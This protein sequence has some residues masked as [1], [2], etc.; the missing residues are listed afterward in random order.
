MIFKSL[1][2]GIFFAFLTLFNYNEGFSQ[3][4]KFGDISVSEFKKT[5][6]DAIILFKYRETKLIFKNMSGWTLQTKVHERIKIN[7][8]KGMDYATKKIKLYNEYHNNDE[9]F[10][11]KAAT[12]N[13][14]NEAIT[15]TKFL[16]KSIYK[17][18]L[19]DR[20]SRLT[21]TMPD[22]KENAIIE[23]E[24]TINS[25]YIFYI[26]DIV[27]QEDIPIK[28]FKA[29]VNIPGD[30]LKFIYRYLNKIDANITNKRG[31]YIENKNV[32]KFKNE[33]FTRNIELYRPKIVF[34]VYA[35]NFPNE[36]YKLYSKTWTDVAKRLN[37][38]ENFGMQLKKSKY[39]K[40]ELP[41]ILSNATSKKDS[42]L[43][44]FNFVK[45]RVKWNGI[46]FIFSKKGVKTA[47]NEKTGNVAEINFILVSMLRKVGFKA[48]PLILNTR[49]RYKALFPTILKVNYVICYVDLGNKDVLL[50]ASDK[51][52]YYNV[53]PYKTLNGVGRVIKKDNTSF[54]VDL[55][56]KTF[57]VT[58]RNISLKINSTG[59]VTGKLRSIF[60]GEKAIINRDRL[61]DLDPVA[62]ELELKNKF[63][64]AHINKVKFN[65]KDQL[66]KPF[67]VSLDFIL[68][69]NFKTDDRIEIPVM[70]LFKQNENII[71]DSK[72]KFPIEFGYPY[73]ESTIQSINLP[74]GYKV[75]KLPENEL[76]KSEDAKM[77]FSF[78]FKQS[79]GMLYIKKVLVLI[80][81]EIL[82]KDYL[83]FK[84]VLSK[85]I[86]IE[87]KSI[88]LVPDK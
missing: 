33:N 15:K 43:A 78:S 49:E 83:E 71:K 6:D 53:L 81:T 58:K 48:D 46:H 37:K 41:Q 73:K 56:P 82:P 18:K 42:I 72:R 69:N 16:K 40:K 55:Y 77:V 24:Y 17:K 52:A 38:D 30:H 12:Y 47:F 65:N 74:K 66:D 13:L 87:N 57:A 34:D 2:F 60:K 7:T 88:V 21:F 27:L 25:N 75:F 67:I 68:G 86:A 22:V 45:N 50:D 20:W 1:F 61:I 28:Y 32:P 63:Q 80:A 8:V 4:K 9:L 51:N 70:S 19:N 62:L 35:T 11:I 79:N 76:V 14:N 85:M 44:I 64:N 5:N 26:N 29:N 54:F 10:T 31:L 39:F 36:A 3:I 59:L 23:W 84:R